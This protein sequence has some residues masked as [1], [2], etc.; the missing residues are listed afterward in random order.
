VH[1]QY[2]ETLTLHQAKPLQAIGQK[3]PASSV[4][5]PSV[6]LSIVGQV[7]VHLL[8][9]LAALALC[10]HHQPSSSQS[11]G[12]ADGRF[13]PNLVNSAVFLLSAVMQ[14]SATIVILIDHYNRFFLK[15]K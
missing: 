7:A 11:S 12:T 8:S 3:R 5:A 1:C 9:L 4:F 13:Q 15:K 10:E 6:A 14:V 2:L